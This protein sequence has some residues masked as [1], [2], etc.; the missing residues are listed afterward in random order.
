[1]KRWKQYLAVLLAA[2]CLFQPLSALAQEAPSG[3]PSPWAAE[4]VAKAI[5]L[6][7]VPE[8][9]QKDYQQEIT[10]GEFARVSLLFLAAQYN[11]YE[12]YF[13]TGLAD[14]EGVV[15]R[16]LE[17][18]RGEKLGFAKTDCQALLDP[19]ETTLYGEDLEEWSWD[20]LLHRIKPFS[21]MGGKEWEIYY[22]HK[23]NA[24]YVLG[25]VKGR[26]DGTFGPHDPIT[27]QEAACMLERVYRLYAREE[28]AQTA[29]LTFPD[30][31]AIGPW[32]AESIALMAE[33]GIMEGIED[34]SFSPT[35]GYTREQCYTTFLRLYE[36]MPTSRAR[37]NLEQLTTWEEE[38]EALVGVFCTRAEVCFENDFAVVVEAFYSGLPHGDSY[39]KSYIL[40]KKGGTRGVD[41]PRPRWEDEDSFRPTGDGEGILFLLEDGQEYLLDLNTGRTSPVQ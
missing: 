19:E 10:R 13:N 3:D 15:I 35:T 6:G 38:R 40:Y 1:M 22:A 24:A 39:D 34:G 26:E 7:I 18:P 33:Y 21:D 27:R 29:P 12:S 16:Y 25:V 28:T 32:A 2:A 9:L 36:N 5:T 23:V 17:S 4:S 31:E 14:D 8:K 41:W 30:R 11:Y 37:G 20:L